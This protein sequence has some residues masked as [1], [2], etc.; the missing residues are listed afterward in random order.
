[1]NIIQGKG[2]E[3]QNNVVCANAGLAIATVNSL[4]PIQGFKIAK[5]SLLSGKALLA[6]N[7]LQQLSK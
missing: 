3:A 1:M 6:L 5:E 4:S 2:T 7:K